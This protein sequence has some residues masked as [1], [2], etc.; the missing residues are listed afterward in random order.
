MTDKKEAVLFKINQINVELDSLMAWGEFVL[1]LMSFAD[2]FQPSR[3]SGNETIHVLCLE[4][5][6]DGA[7]KIDWVRSPT[8]LFQIV[9]YRMVSLRSTELSENDLPSYR[10][11]L[12]NAKVSTRNSSD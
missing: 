4:A 8:R 9:L 11:H 10:P 3:K 7:R 1:V 2:K 5:L 12:R 6:S